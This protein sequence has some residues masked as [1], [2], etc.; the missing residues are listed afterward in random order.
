MSGI[1]DSLM[2][3]AGKG[4]PGFSDRYANK[5]QRD[6][7]NAM[8]SEKDYSE[9]KLGQ[10]E[11]GMKIDMMDPNS[12]MSKQLQSTYA[13]LFEKLGYKSDAILKMPASEIKSALAMAVESGGKEM[14]NLI[15]LYEAQSNIGLRKG[16]LEASTAEASQ[17]AGLEESKLK[18]SAASELLK[19]GNTKIWGIPVPFTGP[20]G[21]ETEAAKNVLMENIG[22]GPKAETGPLGQTTV[23]DGITYEWSPISRKYH[24]KG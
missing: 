11:S 1:G 5:Q 10:L 2:M 19:R 23:R 17:K 24:P 12:P 3:V 22:A 7:E 20:S 14:E 13:P 21:K 4:N 18:Q 8:K 6:F 16:A 15:K 9:G